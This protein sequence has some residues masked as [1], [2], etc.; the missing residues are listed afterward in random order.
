[1]TGRSHYAPFEKPRETAAWSHW[2]HLFPSGQ[3]S[4]ACA[5]VSGRRLQYRGGDQHQRLYRYLPLGLRLLDLAGLQRRH[6]AHR[7][8][9]LVLDPR[10]GA[11]LA[12]RSVRLPAPME[13]GAG[14]LWQ[15]ATLNARLDRHR[16]GH[17]PDG[18]AS[19]TA[20]TSSCGAP[21]LRR[22]LARRSLCSLSDSLHRNT[23]PLQLT[24][25][26]E[27][28]RHT[29]LQHT[30]QRCA[31]GLRSAPSRFDWEGT[32]KRASEPEGRDWTLRHAQCHA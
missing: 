14:A 3:T 26:F 13:R 30:W 17:L 9:R 7:V 4:P 28:Q 1:M 8:L 6:R 27:A 5:G 16:R 18:V 15:R 31:N 29:R 25:I 11:A 24:Q 23:Q 2:S 10:D 21:D 32:M 19:W 12:R 20:R 22:T